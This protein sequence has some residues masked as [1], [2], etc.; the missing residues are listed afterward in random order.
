M[1]DLIWSFA[2]WLVFLLAARITSLYG[3]VAAGAVAAILVLVRAIGRER[4]H[5]LDVASTVYFVALGAVLIV[6]HPGHLD[7]WARYAQA[8]SH[9]ALTLLVF[10]SI[11]VGRPFTESY[12]RET[13]PEEVWRTERFHA[14]NRRISMV[15]GLAF[16]VG[17]VSLIAAGS[18]DS[19]QV[20]LRIIV[21]FGALYYAYVFTQKQTQGVRRAPS[22]PDGLAADAGTGSGIRR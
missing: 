19:R 13:T 6:V 10:G 9:V 21:P 7:F 3:A 18:V 17:T 11:V 12:A 4:V 15:W 16:L 14:L 5:M 1:T 22:T 8:G 2:P 20:L